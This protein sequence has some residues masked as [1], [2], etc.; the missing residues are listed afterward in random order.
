MQK[1]PPTEVLDR[2]IANSDQHSFHGSSWSL[3]AWE[4]GVVFIGLYLHLGARIIAPM[5]FPKVSGIRAVKQIFGGDG[6]LVAGVGVIKK[7]VENPR[8]PGLHVAA[9]HELPLRAQCSR[10]GLLDAILGLIRVAHQVEG[11]AVQM[12]EVR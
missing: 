10:T 8:Q 4:I 6:A 11:D 1:S 9:R 3:E 7:I 2:P 12:I 5:G